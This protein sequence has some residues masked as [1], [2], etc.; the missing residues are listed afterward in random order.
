MPGKAMPPNSLIGPKGWQ[1]LKESDPKEW[2]SRSQSTQL[3]RPI[4][5][6]LT[7]YLTV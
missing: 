1:P 6:T 2:T 3:K 4:T 5:Y 7:N